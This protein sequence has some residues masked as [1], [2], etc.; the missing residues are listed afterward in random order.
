MI[1]FQWF[2]LTPGAEQSAFTDGLDIPLEDDF[3]ELKAQR[4]KI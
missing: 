4:T 3:N 1:S 2:N